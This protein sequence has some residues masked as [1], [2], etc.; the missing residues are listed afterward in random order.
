MPVMELCAPYEPEF[1]VL[2]VMAYML[3][4]SDDEQHA[5]LRRSY[6]W[7][8][9]ALY[10][11][12][13]AE[14]EGR[15]AVPVEIFEE[16]ENIPSGMIPDPE[17]AQVKQ[18]LAAG[19]IL[20]YL[21][22]LQANGTKPSF[23]KAYRLADNFIENALNRTGNPIASSKPSVQRAW[24][25]YKSVSH[26][27]AACTHLVEEGTFSLKHVSLAHQFAELTPTIKKSDGKT[28]VLSKELLWVLPDSI[29][30]PSC[31]LRDTGLDEN[32]NEILLK[33]PTGSITCWR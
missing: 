28:E 26:L 33:H 1:L 21:L 22:K 20:Y 11:R 3:F 24:T 15:Q 2:E 27:W 17:E 6:F 14:N 18:A 32:E 31:T 19:E 10:E 23:N 30:L 12:I 16:L 29:L 25:T 4:P 7:K 13:D 8:N 5:I 9:R